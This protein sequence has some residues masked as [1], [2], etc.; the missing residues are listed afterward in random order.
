MSLPEAKAITAIWS[1]IPKE[2]EEE[3]RK[4]HN[5]EHT[6][7]RLEGPGYI[8]CR[9]Y[10]SEGGEGHH[11]RLTVF[12]GEDLATFDSPY[13]RESRNNPTPWTQKSMGVIKDAR[14]GVYTLEATSGDR[15][16]V[17]PPYIYTFRCDP[18]EGAEAEVIS[19]YRE[20]HLPRLCALD[21]VVRARLFRRDA[22]SDEK[23]AETKMQGKQ[24]GQQTLI[25][26]YEMSPLEPIG[27][28]EWKEAATG[29]SRSAE[30][31]GKLVGPIREMW[32]WDFIKYAPG[33]IK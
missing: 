1:N 2:K 17:E 28:A 21:C 29:T 9:R 3:I 25:A 19:W 31:I 12:E 14:R 33:R 20:E 18:T 30:T 10:N 13:Y 11:K 24:D 26:I 27:S 8:A 23:T 7:E 6:T 4:W 5:L 32:W 15:P 16:R 22:V